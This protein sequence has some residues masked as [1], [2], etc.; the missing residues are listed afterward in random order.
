VAAVVRRVLENPDAVAEAVAQS[1]RE[2]VLETLKSRKRFSFA[3]AGGSTPK[4][5]LEAISKLENV[6]WGK[7]HVFF[8]DERCVPP[9]DD[10]SNFKMLKLALL[11]HVNIPHGNVHRIKGEQGPEAARAEY[12]AQ[13]ELYFD[14]PIIFDLVHLG[15]GPDGHIASLFP[16]SAALESP[17]QVVTS[18]PGPTLQPQVARV[19]LGLSVLN[20][21]RNVQLIVTG[22]SKADVLT[23]LEP[24]NLPG[25]RVQAVNTTWFLDRAANGTN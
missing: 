11:D 4:L 21:A 1:F 13:L 3:A 6:P 18:F 9:D 14:G 15:L 5:A 25:A 2:L 23:R 8:G 12:L 16:G 19:S 7:V 24:E 17:D 22:S 20:A 10:Q